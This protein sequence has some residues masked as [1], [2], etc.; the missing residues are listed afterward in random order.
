MLTRDRD[1]QSQTRLDGNEVSSHIKCAVRLTDD[2][3]T[4][5]GDTL[6]G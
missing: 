6:G 4:Q 2:N 1:N 3:G 5:P